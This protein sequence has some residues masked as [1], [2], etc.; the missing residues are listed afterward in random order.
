LFRFS[1]YIINRSTYCMFVSP[2][3]KVHIYIEYHSVCPLV[4]IRPPPLSSRR[5]CP[6]PPGTKGGS[7]TRQRVRVPI[8]TTGY[9]AQSSVYSM[10][11]TICLCAAFC[12]LVLPKW[13]NCF[14]PIIL[15]LLYGIN[16]NVSSPHISGLYSPK[17]GASQSSPLPSTQPTL[18]TA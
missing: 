14:C 3:H 5:V 8:R 1:Y 12:D 9:K 4:R 16:R 11:Q 15:C 10:S 2:D 7:H 13:C 6:P 17:M 18:Y